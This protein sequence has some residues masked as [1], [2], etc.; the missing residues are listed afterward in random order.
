MPG[1][2][3]SYI[4][5]YLFFSTKYTPIQLK[6]E[7]VKSCYSCLFANDYSCVEEILEETRKRLID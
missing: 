3:S 1:Y 2:A 6:K 4:I 7:E 5:Q